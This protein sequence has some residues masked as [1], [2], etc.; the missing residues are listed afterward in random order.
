MVLPLL[1][2]VKSGFSDGDAIGLHG[3]RA[4]GSAST[5][6][7]VATETADWTGSVG[8]RGRVHGVDGGGGVPEG[9]CRLRLPRWV[10]RR[11]AGWQ[12]KVLK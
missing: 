11:R 4:R 5:G 6:F 3:C 8:E 10:T 2:A 1:L 7:T 9:Q 12:S